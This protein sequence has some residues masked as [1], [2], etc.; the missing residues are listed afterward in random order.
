MKLFS[1]ISLYLHTRYVVCIA[2]N[3]WNHTHLSTNSSYTIWQCRYRLPCLLYF[4][5]LYYWTVS[6]VFFLVFT[7]VCI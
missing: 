4:D 6:V 7:F 1:C 5:F 2:C 3:R